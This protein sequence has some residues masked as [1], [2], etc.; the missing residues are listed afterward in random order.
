MFSSGIVSA[1]VPACALVSATPG[2]PLTG[3]MSAAGG[4]MCGDMFSIRASDSASRLASL[5]AISGGS[6]DMS[7]S[8]RS[9]VG[10]PS[11]AC[12]DMS[13]VSGNPSAGSIESL[14]SD[15][16]DLDLFAP[17]NKLKLGI[18]ADPE[19]VRFPACRFVEVGGSTCCDDTEAKEE[20]LAMVD[21]GSGSPLPALDFG[22]VDEEVDDP[23]IL[24]IEGR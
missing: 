4:R 7:T 13:E 12:K 17:P 19:L 9:E 15:S 14:L 2:G 24:G 18:Q 8:V 3:E 22:N 10:P 6:T 16:L 23:G 11:E 1:R 21:F 5:A 20:G